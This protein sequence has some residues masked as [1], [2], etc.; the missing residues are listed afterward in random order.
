MA[1]LVETLFPYQKKFR[2]SSQRVSF[3]HAR[4]LCGRFPETFPFIDRTQ[5]TLYFLAPFESIYNQENNKIIFNFFST[6]KSG[7]Q[8]KETQEFGKIEINRHGRGRRRRRL[9]RRW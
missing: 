1:F 6:K 3:D 9:R 4:E 5:S 7:C 2:N 8:K